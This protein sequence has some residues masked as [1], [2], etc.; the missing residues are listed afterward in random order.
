L[1]AE[2]LRSHHRDYRRETA[3]QISNLSQM[4]CGILLSG[5]K[6]SSENA[7]YVDSGFHPGLFAIPYK[8]IILAGGSGTRLYPVTHAVC[9]ELLPIYDNPMI[10]YPLSTL[11]WR[12]SGYSPL[13]PPPKIC[14]S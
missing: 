6:F 13:S 3:M 8:G 11:M 9:Q 12:G 14:R 5:R 1:R 2:H 4:S 10:Y 7:L